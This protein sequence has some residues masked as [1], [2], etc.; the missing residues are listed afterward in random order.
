MHTL[1]YPDNY[2]RAFTRKYLGSIT[3]LIFD[4]I[5]FTSICSIL[6]LTLHLFQDKYIQ[7]ITVSNHI[8]LLSLNLNPFVLDI[9][10]TISGSKFEINN[11]I[12]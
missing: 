4:E 6:S 3:W 7:V 2:L 12:Y 5:L 11:N 1:V 9:A 10:N 8:Y